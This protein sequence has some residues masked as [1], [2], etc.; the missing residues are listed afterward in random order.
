MNAPARLFS[1]ARS[2]DVAPSDDMAVYRPKETFS[3]RKVT[4]VTVLQ[5]QRLAKLTRAWSALDRIDNPA[6]KEWGEAEAIRRLIDAAMDAAW[7]E[8]GGEPKDEADLERHVVA[9]AKAK[10]KG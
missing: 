9:Y 8:I 7:Q 6:A 5:A 3:E 10:K 4:F 1:G 2:K